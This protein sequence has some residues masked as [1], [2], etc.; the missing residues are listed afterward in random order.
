MAALD[1]IS[2]NSYG[3]GT[4]KEIVYLLHLLKTLD[5]VQ[6]CFDKGSNDTA[7]LQRFTLLIKYLQNTVLDKKKRIS[8]QAEMDVEEKRLIAEGKYDEI[9][10]EYL[11]GFIVVREVMQY[12]ND[13]VEFEHTDIIGLVN[14]PKDIVSDKLLE[15]GYGDDAGDLIDIEVR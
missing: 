1:N 11:L 3:G 5:T 14:Y 2:H 7:Q 13:V 12:L 15:D 8:I 9:V 10:R 6:T 4:S